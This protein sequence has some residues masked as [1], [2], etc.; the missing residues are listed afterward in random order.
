MQLEETYCQWKALTA[1]SSFVQYLR[2]GESID[3]WCW[4]LN[5]ILWIKFHLFPGWNTWL[6]VA[7]TAGCF[8][9]NHSPLLPSEQNFHFIIG[10][11]VPGSKTTF[12]RLPCSQTWL[13]SRWVELP[14]KTS[15]GLTQLEACSFP[16]PFLL[17]PAWNT[18]MIRGETEATRQG[19]G[20]EWQEPGSPDSMKPPHIPQTAYSTRGANWYTLA[21]TRALSPNF[22]NHLSKLSRQCNNFLWNSSVG[23]ISS[24]NLK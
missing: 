11:D 7:E 18:D 13:V 15:K 1:N 3:H 12:P 24:L 23:L 9:N 22:Q 4:W 2:A 8:P 14:G 6:S 16:T 19:C 5:S 20:A 10:G 17:L 21:Q